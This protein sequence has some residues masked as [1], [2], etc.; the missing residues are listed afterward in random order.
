MNEQINSCPK[1]GRKYWKE[2][3]DGLLISNDFPL[4]RSYC[5]ACLKEL[6]RKR[7]ELL[8]VKE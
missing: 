5:E 8:K 4:Y 1:H 6:M 3:R 7:R 2:G